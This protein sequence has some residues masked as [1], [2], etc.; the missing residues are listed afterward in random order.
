MCYATGLTASRTE[1]PFLAYC[2]WKESYKRTLR[3]DQRR[4]SDGMVRGSTWPESSIILFSD[5]RQNSKVRT[6]SDSLQHLELLASSMQSEGEKK[7]QG[8][9]APLTFH[10]NAIFV[11]TAI[12]QEPCK[13]HQNA[14]KDGIRSPSHTGVDNVQLYPFMHSSAQGSSDKMYVKKATF[15]SPVVS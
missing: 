9:L 13:P 8:N 3:S 1:A 14:N 15:L 4:Q 7:S 5:P 12:V 10:R 11:H 2:L 6:A